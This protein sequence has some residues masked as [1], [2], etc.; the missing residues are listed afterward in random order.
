MPLRPVVPELPEVETTLRGLWPHLQDRRIQ[1]V[2]LRR[3]DLR[4]PIPDDIAVLRDIPILGLSRRA[5]YLLMDLPHGTAIWHLGMTGNMRV[6]PTDIPTIAHDHV[7]FILDNDTLLRFH[8]PRRFGALLWQSEGTTH[9][10][11][12]HLGPEPLDAEFSADYLFEK[13]R[14]RSIAIKPFLMTQTVVV[15]VG[16]IYANE[17]LFAAGIHPA[18]AAGRISRERYEAL[19]D[20]IKQILLR[21][22]DVGGTTLR[23]FISPDGFSGYF[24]Q[25]LQ[26]YGR[27]G[28][29]CVRCGSTLKSSMLG[30]RQT[31]WCGGC[32]R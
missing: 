8:D 13:S 2:I 23:D 10:V 21:A 26:V 22:I 14:G 3:P 5:K 16:N 4:W 9:P 31:V 27:A 17:A 30:Q 28:E 18:R 25:Q 7:D 1:R 11:L 19:V 32:Q 12:S 29:P 15:G 6:I 24:V 20:H